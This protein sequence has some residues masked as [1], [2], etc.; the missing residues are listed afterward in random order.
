VEDINED[1]LA[2][3]LYGL[4]LK[5]KDSP[6]HI[7][8]KA[9]TLFNEAYYMSSIL[10]HDKNPSQHLEEYAKEIETDLGWH[11]SVDLVF[12]LSYALLNAK[13]R[14]PKK[15]LALMETMK[16]RYGDSIYW[17]TFTQPLSISKKKQSKTI[18]LDTTDLLKYMEKYHC[19]PF[20]QVQQ[21]DIYVNSPGNIVSKEIKYGK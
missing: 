6:R 10:E 3:E 17:K 16:D 14:L 9:E 5:V 4:F 18:K 7:S 11:Y 1:P 20:I 2:E 19:V 8:I 13:K 12:P 21:A 15:M